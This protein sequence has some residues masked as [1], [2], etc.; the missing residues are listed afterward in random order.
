VASKTKTQGNT[1]A[2]ESPPLLNHY[3][4]LFAFLL[5]TIVTSAAY[6]NS[7]NVPFVFDDSQAIV[8]NRNIRHIF[9]LDNEAGTGSMDGPPM[10]TVAARPLVCLSLAIN[11]AISADRVWSY[12]VVNLII[13]ILATLFL[14][15]IVRRTLLRP[16]L[17]TE[18]S[19]SATLLAFISALI[20]AVHPLQTESVTYTIQRCESMMGLFFFATLY[21]AIRGWDSPSRK[22]FW[23]A[24]AVLSSAAGMMTKEVMVVA[25]LIVLFYDYL[26]NASPSVN[27]DSKSQ[28]STASVQAHGLHTS[29]PLYAGLMLTWFILLKIMLS[30]K[31]Q[32]ASNLDINFL[33]TPP[34]VYL[35]TQGKIILYYL[36]LC[37]W[38]DPLCID[39]NWPPAGTYLEVLPYCIVLGALLYVSVR[40]CMKGYP[41]GFLGAWFFLILAPTSSILP[42]TDL[43]FEHRMYVPLAAVVVLAVTLAHR[44]ITRFSI[45]PALRRALG[46]GLAAL[47]IFPL[48]IRTYVRNHDYRSDVALWDTVLKIVDSSRAHNNRGNAFYHEGKNEE[49]LKDF[50]TAVLLDPHNVDAL[51]NY[52]NAINETGDS[53][54]AIKYYDMAIRLRPTFAPVHSN[55]GVALGNLSRFSEAVDSFKRCLKIDPD[56]L[57]AHINIGV[58]YDALGEYDEAISHLNTALKLSPNHPKA[59]NNLGH[60]ASS[61]KKRQEAIAY[62]KQSIAADPKF[63]LALLNLGVEYDFLNDF[64]EAL[65][66]FRAAIAIPNPK[67]PVAAQCWSKIGYVLERQKQT[68]EALKAYRTALGIDRKLSWTANAISAL[69]EKSGR[70]EEALAFWKEMLQSQPKDYIANSHLGYLY[71]KKEKYEV[72]IPYLR[73]AIAAYDNPDVH[74]KLATALACTGKKEEAVAELR[75]YVRMLP[76]DMPEKEKIIAFDRLGQALLDTGKTDEAIAQFKET[77]RKYPNAD[78][79]HVNLGSLYATHKRYDEAL[80]EFKQALKITPNLWPARDKLC[81]LLVDRG[82]AMELSGKIT[83]AVA[84][85]KMAIESDENEPIYHHHLGRLL[86]ELGRPAEAIPHFEAEIR[87]TGDKA[88][89][90]QMDLGFALA[91]L[92]KDAL[93]LEHLREALRLEPDNIERKCNIALAMEKMGV[94]EEAITV[95]RDVIKRQPSFA[96]AYNDM[97]IA[98]SGLNREQEALDALKEVLRLEPE[99]PGAEANMGIVFGRLNK[100]DEAIDHYKKALKL[101]A[102][103]MNTRDNYARLLARI[104]RGTEALT[105]FK[106][107]LRLDPKNVRAYIGIGNGLAAEG[108]LSEA[109]ATFTEALRIN[110]SDGNL[111]NCLGAAL[112]R[113]KKYQ[114]AAAHFNEALKANP[115]DATARENLAHVMAHLQKSPEP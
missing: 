60:V 69:L 93:A 79:T 6:R 104:G 21:F 51:D 2:P 18:F 114:E 59:L 25:P 34:I 11:Y 1:E 52:A 62:F 17:R 111:H 78:V 85:W 77:L 83:D 33:R 13:H 66:V 106:E 73:S 36:R 16:K 65:K 50:Q 99:F 26:L 41:I 98:L 75:E 112:A 94:G 45:D 58:S 95:Y 80:A 57:D 46:A 5:I 12:H 84:H 74:N 109:V 23:H 31:S 110:P 107:L 101:N 3:H 87:M 103:D 19:R 76:E 88:A 4:T 8:T 81:H 7:F 102:R 49:A 32:A 96:R 71:F 15:G 56:F 70:D 42:I 72:S 27:S 100:P 54:E 39:Y 48:G 37:V 22:L 30:G 35:V 67:P 115:G 38:P 20:F 89:G 14:F 43:A 44:M 105:E 28:A 40:A 91:Q 113:Q 9:P 92:G 53:V 24:L 97:A 64:D 55:R 29:I 86:M 90:A 61:Q 82:Q 68:D 47:A 10:T 63:A 108:K